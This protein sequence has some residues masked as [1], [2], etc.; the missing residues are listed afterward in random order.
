M[1]PHK[2]V[3]PHLRSKLFDIQII[4]RETMNFYKVLRGVLYSNIANIVIAEQVTIH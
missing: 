1:R 3:G 2:N 4:W